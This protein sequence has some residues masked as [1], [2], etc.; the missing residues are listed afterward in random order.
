[1]LAAVAA[2]TL[3]LGGCSQIT[4]QIDGSDAS[5]ETEPVPTKPILVTRHWALNDDMLSVV[6]Q[7]TSDRTLRYADGVITARSDDNQLLALSVDSADA[8]CC[9]V[10]ELPPGQQYGFYLDVDDADAERISR[11]EVSYR[12][13]S[14]A[15]AQQPVGKDVGK[16]VDKEQVTARAVG[17]EQDGPDTVVLADLVSTASVREV[18]AQAFISGPDGEFV[19][20]ISGR[21]QC[22]ERGTR[23]IRMQLFHPVP[24]GARVDRVVVHPVLDDPTQ[25]EPECAPT[26]DPL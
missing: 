24:D 21:W 18:V 3:A 7:N 10:V 20:V 9:G 14:W 2:G 15:Q 25:G 6:V 5:A 11:V 19:A 23:R 26:A 12:N 4:D 16:D 22:L 1:M 8:G 17:I 13:V